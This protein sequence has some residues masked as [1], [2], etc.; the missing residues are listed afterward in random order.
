MDYNTV[1]TKNKLE[2][3]LVLCLAIKD[4][5]VSRKFSGVLYCFE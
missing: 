2:L 1:S 3:V 5:E 4:E